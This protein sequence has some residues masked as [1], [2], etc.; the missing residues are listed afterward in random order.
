M[1]GDGGG[2]PCNLAGSALGALPGGVRL[3]FAPRSGA[4][5]PWWCGSAA[6]CAVSLRFLGEAQRCEVGAGLGLSPMGAEGPDP[7]ARRPPVPPFWGPKPASG[8]IFSTPISTLQHPVT[9]REQREFWGGP[10]K[11]GSTCIECLPKQMEERISDDICG[12]KER[13][14]LASGDAGARERVE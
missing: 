14:A 5:C 11:A 4:R 10:R 3:M 8:R 12:R 1:V 2:S 9:V 13:R 6:R 7:D